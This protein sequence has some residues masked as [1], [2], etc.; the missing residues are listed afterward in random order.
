M[1]WRAVPASSRQLQ[2]HSNDAAMATAHGRGNSHAL[3]VEHSSAIRSEQIAST[4]GF[5]DAGD[6]AAYTS[7]A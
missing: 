3:N 4:A 2:V 7:T 6:V 5:T 1:S